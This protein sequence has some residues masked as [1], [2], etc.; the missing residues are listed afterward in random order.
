VYPRVLRAHGYRRELDALLEA[1]TDPRHP[2]LPAAAGRLAEEVLLFGT[3]HEG[4]ELA[5][6]WQA[7]ADTL[8]L[9][10]PFGQAP[11]D[12]LAMIDAVAPHGDNRRARVHCC[13]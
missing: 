13:A 4:A 8:A 1:N 2:V 3:F 5:R 9:V 10:A 11:G 6:R 7:H 12:I